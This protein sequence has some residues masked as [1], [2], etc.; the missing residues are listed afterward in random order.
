MSR[1]ALLAALL[2]ACSSSSGSSGSS[3]SPPRAHLE[4]TIG[5]IQGAP[6]A[7][8]AAGRFVVPSSGPWQL[9]GVTCE[10]AGE[11]VTF[12]VETPG[13][14]VELGPGGELSSWDARSGATLAGA[15]TLELS[16]GAAARVSGSLE[17]PDVGQGC[18]AS[19]AV[20]LEGCAE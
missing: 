5:T 12:T 20:V 18:T 7:C 9:E 16:E 17:C 19:V 3:S 11:G 14:V 4:V 13:A 10:L 15:C 2:G 6:V 1:G 8:T